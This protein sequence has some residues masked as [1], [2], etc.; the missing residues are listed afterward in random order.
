MLWIDFAAQGPESRR[1]E[2]ASHLGKVLSLPRSHSRALSRSRSRPR[3]CSRSRSRSRSLSLS[4]ALSLSLSPPASTLLFACRARCRQRG[5]VRTV[6]G[7][8]CTAI[9]ESVL[10]PR[11]TAVFFVREALRALSA[12]YWAAKLL[13]QVASLPLQM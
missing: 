2:S 9:T 6:G 8:V 12:I 3:C 10:H 5:I 11:R 1:V 13:W 7:A 4:R